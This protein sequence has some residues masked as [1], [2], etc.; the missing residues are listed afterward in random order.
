MN[1]TTFWAYFLGSRNYFGCWV[2]FTAPPQLTLSS[3]FSLATCVELAASFGANL[4]GRWS[5]ASRCFPWPRGNLWETRARSFHC[6]LSKIAH[7]RSWC[8]HCGTAQPISS[9]ACW[10]WL[11]CHCVF[12]SI[13]SCNCLDFIFIVGSKRIGCSQLS[14]LSCFHPNLCPTLCRPISVKLA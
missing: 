6:Y 8:Y 12:P 7:F 2:S 3:C 1:S 13:S 11:C 4:I 10:N 5:Y 9:S 14:H